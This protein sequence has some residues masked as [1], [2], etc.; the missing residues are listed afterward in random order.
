MDDP[1]QAQ[2]YA[3]ANCAPAHDAFVAYFKEYFP[4]H[5]VNEVL[6]LGC[7][8]ADV[9]IRFARA[10]PACRVTGI[11]A[12]PAMLAC[13]AQAVAAAGLPDRMHFVQAYLGA[14]PSPVLAA[15]RYDTVISNSLLHH[16]AAPESLW[17]AIKN[18][19]AASAAVW[20]MDLRRPRSLA[21]A[22]AL[23]A[24]YAHAEPPLF[25]RDFYN[26]LLAAYTVEEVAAQIAHAGLRE[27]LRVVAIGD[28]HWA[29]FGTL[30]ARTPRQIA[31]A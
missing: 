23:V 25:Q 24:Q 2:A 21:A 5:P 4:A 6:D 20:V 26:S 31:P 8:S 12:A 27:D 3:A 17:T 29:V 13:A 10:F 22:R 19:A 18:C 11:D 30:G 28:R 9:G 15:H 1:A 16:L 7:G 14:T